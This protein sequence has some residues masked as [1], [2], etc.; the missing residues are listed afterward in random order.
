MQLEE[1]H[2]KASRRHDE[3][4]AA[5]AERQTR[6][7]VREEIVVAKA[8]AAAA[9]AASAAASQHV[10]DLARRLGN[11]EARVAQLEGTRRQ[12]PRLPPPE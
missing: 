6:A 10:A 11:L 5:L 9:T 12:P 3:L 7:E 1:S 2:A 8:E 4:I